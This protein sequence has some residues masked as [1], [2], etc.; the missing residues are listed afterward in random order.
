[1]ECLPALVMPA[2]LHVLQ[3]VLHV[4]EQLVQLVVSDQKPEFVPNG[5][6]PK[7]FASK[8]IET[9]FAALLHNLV[10]GVKPSFVEHLGMQ[11]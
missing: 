2:A 11:R 5:T 6:A 1:M 3:T 8:P 9:G 7:G 4:P 10:L